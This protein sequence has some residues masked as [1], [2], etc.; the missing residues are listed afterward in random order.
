MAK[1]GHRA[2]LVTLPLLFQKYNVTRCWSVR[3]QEKACAPD[4]APCH[5][6]PLLP[7]NCPTHSAWAT[8][9]SGKWKGSTHVAN[10]T[11][12]SFGPWEPWEC[13]SR[14]ACKTRVR[15]HI[16]MS[17]N[18]WSSSTAQNPVDSLTPPRRNQLLAFLSKILFLQLF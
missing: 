14:Q 5:C 11:F 8:C 12:L 2:S 15:S 3:G 16:H 4:P 10:V 17:S 6:R 9:V 13:S 18:S 1:N 7:R